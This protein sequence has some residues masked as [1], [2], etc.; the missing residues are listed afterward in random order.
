MTGHDADGP[1]GQSRIDVHFLR[2]DP[3]AERIRA[4]RGLLSPDEVVRADRL[5]Y[6]PHGERF[7]AG[8]GQLREVLGSFL[9]IHPAGVRFR[10]SEHGK[11][12]LSG[13]DCGLFFSISR[14][15]SRG[16][17]AVT[18]SR[19]VGLDL[20]A[21]V[22]RIGQM[23]LA[24]DVLSSTEQRELAALPEPQ[25]LGA[26]FRCWTRKEAALKAI[27]GGPC[28]DPRDFTMPLAPAPAPIHVQGWTIL[29]LRVEGPYCASLAVEG[30][31]IGPVV[32]RRWPDEAV[33]RGDSW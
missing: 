33:S 21:V 14:S 23:W 10:Y 31:T 3:P 29:D 7:T 11:P 6:A 22:P 28:I 30:D 9:G 5:R 27:E 2:L 17:L 25:R 18:R 15:S 26:F 19:R 12:F 4:L 16:M 1:N 13:P 32:Y 20:E 8:R 24:R